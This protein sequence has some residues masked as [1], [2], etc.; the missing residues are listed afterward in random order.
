MEAARTA[1][2]GPA[3]DPAPAPPHA[4]ALRLDD[5]LALRFSERHHAPD[6]YRRIDA[7]REHLAA[8]FGWARQA[9][10][11]SI[12]ARLAGWLEQWRR[13]DGWHADLC[14][15]GTPVGAMWLHMLQARGG[16]T[17]V[18]YWLIEAFEGRGLLT[19]A[20]QG[21]QRHFFEGRALGR[22]AIAV[23]PRNGESA[24][25]A[26]RLGYRP[27]AVLRHAHQGPDGSPAQLAFHG[28]LRED[29]EAAAGGAA[30]PLPLPR[31]A[32]RVD[33][34]L[35]LALLERDDARPLAE[36]VDAN[37][38]H[39]R[40]WMPWAH[41]T[42]PRAT[43]GFIEQRALPAIAA[44]DG[45]ELGVWWRG[46]LV[47][48]CGMHSVGGPPKRGSLGYWLAADA[49]GHGLVTRA[50]RALTA[51]AFADHGCDRVDLR[52]DVANARSRA[53]AERL[54][55]RFEGVLPRAFWNGRAYVDQAVYALLR[56][57]WGGDA[58]AGA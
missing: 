20:M 50:M 28:L 52:A 47:G 27:E 24:A 29:W 10:A 13:S 22:V 15:R 42:S 48:A 44:A 39:L 36:L 38:A 18:G 8:A 4:F 11:A 49:Q 2:T 43:L 14:W 37:R 34:E 46:R 16:S 51:K 17:E 1:P 40:P 21:L 54:G 45:F 33:E 5:E 26:R 31:F 23:D 25:V 57:E 3:P 56:A 35:E 41:D 30:G 55:F 7:E 53:V 58:A 12:E 9:T 19:R 32:L 6:L